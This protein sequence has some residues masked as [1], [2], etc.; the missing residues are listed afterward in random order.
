MTV[1]WIRDLINGM[2][3][4]MGKLALEMAKAVSYSLLGLLIHFAK[5]EK[6]GI[7]IWFMNFEKTFD[8][9]N[10]ANFVLKLI[11]DGC[12]KQFTKA[13]S[14][15]CESTAYT[16]LVGKNKIGDEI[17]TSYWVAQVRYT[18]YF[19]LQTCPPVQ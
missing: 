15:M 7:F 6:Q 10:R 16:P 9:A 14:K 12:G 4:I 3:L 2:F 18:L 19:M 13:V 17:L 8:Y 11:N 5:E 1:E